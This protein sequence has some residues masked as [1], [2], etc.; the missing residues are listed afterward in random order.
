MAEPLK[1]LFNQELVVSLASL[2]K[3]NYTKF[4][5]KNFINDVFD[6]TWDNKELKQRM[7]HITVCLHK[8]IPLPYPEQVK[9][10]SAAAPNFKGFIAMFFPDFIEVYGLDD[11]DISA[12]ALEH[13]TQYSSSEFAVRPFIVK[14]PKQML[15]QH[16]KWAQ[17]K[18]HHVRRLASEGIRP[19]LPW[20]MALPEFKKDPKPILPILELL[21]NDESEYVRKSVA[22]CLNDISKDHP[23]VL[24]Q[25][26][27]NWKG[28]SK[29][30]DWI[31][32]HASR[33]LL[34][35]GNVD[36]LKTF[37]LNEQVHAKVTQL[38]ISKNTLKIG[39]EFSFETS[40]LLLDKTPHDIRVEYNIYFMKSNGKH[41]PKIFQIGTY[42]LNPKQEITIKR[43][44]KFANLTTRKHYTGEHTLAII[45]NGKEL[46]RQSF[47]LQ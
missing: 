19:R 28:N 7:R 3:K 17:H 45:V 26:V 16:K 21:K 12:K 39:D 1:N 35:Q 9:I 10:L 40:I 24:L 4:N 31:V 20:A 13:F 25:T 33:G 6:A 23:D 11:F 44:H 37:G 32:K 38:K 43:K 2:I 15:A 5:T 14:Y 47:M 8:H 30:T 22:N 34:K 42:L 36:A 29:V 41:A 46:A 27:N 18:N